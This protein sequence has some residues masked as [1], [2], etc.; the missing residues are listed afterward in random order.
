MAAENRFL[1]CDPAACE[2]Y[3]FLRWIVRLRWVFFSL[4][5]LLIICGHNGLWRVGR[6]S[7]LY[8]SVAH[9]IADGKG[10][11]FRGEP[12]K[13]I[14]PGMPLLLAGVEKIFGREADPL[15]PSAIL[16][17]MLLIS[18]GT[19]WSVHAMIREF[20]PRWIAVCVTSGVGINQAFSQ[21]SHEI[22]SDMPF[23]LGVCLV[24]IGVGRFYNGKDKRQA[25][26][27]LILGALIALLMRPT[28]IALGFAGFIA[29]MAYGFQTKRWKWP[30][31]GTATVLALILIGFVFLN[32]SGNVFKGKYVQNFMTYINDAGHE[33]RLD[34]C[35][36]LFRDHL[37]EMLFGYDL[38]LPIALVLAGLLF[39]SLCRRSLRFPLWGAY[40]LS[41]LLMLGIMGS[42]TRYLL[43]V[44]PM[45][46]VEWALMV[47]AFARW[48]RKIIPWRF[49]VDWA[50]LVG[51]GFATAIHIPLSLDLAM[52]QR[53][54][55]Y[56]RGK[57]YVY[58]GFYSVYREGMNIHAILNLAH[59]IQLEVPENQAVVGPES[60]ILTFLSGRNVFGPDDFRGLNTREKWISH[61]QSRQV[62][63]A[64]WGE[65]FNEETGVSVAIWTR[66]IGILP[67]QWQEI[68][69]PGKDA[70][71]RLAGIYF[72]KLFLGKA[73]APV[74]QPAS[75]SLLPGFT[76]LKKNLPA[77][78]PASRPATLPSET[79]E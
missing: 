78:R 26:T 47:H 3:W 57:G 11:S 40:V 51:L 59:V 49:S 77:K 64:I 65:R 72:G 74:T 68:E 22:M 66:L 71:G 18:L 46:L 32:P 21:H 52:Q 39:G 79:T 73:S 76:E 35:V 55:E 25:W 24:F 8:R 45:L 28:V 2:E 29:A 53:G 15:K 37:P 30:L 27:F 9:N 17:V 50:I 43:M 63:Y 61:L 62:N 60:R 7:S 41:T 19:L 42:V 6:D 33:N 31:V 67:N 44:L 54:Y 58:H 75:R 69:P 16:I 14:F 20:F 4:V 70:N 56:I 38:P 1:A 36:K 10:F 48:V 13:Q 23:L 12:E 5:I 34:K